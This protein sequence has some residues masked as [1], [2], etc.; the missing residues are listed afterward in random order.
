MD[1]RGGVCKASGVSVSVF[2][3]LIRHDREVATHSLF[4]QRQEQP[5][6]PD[7]SRQSGCSGVRLVRLLQLVRLVWLVWLVRLIRPVATRDN[8]D[9]SVT[10]HYID[11]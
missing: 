1:V 4:V 6:C 5:L 8:A 3:L 2:F 11:G 9:M 10:C 7:S